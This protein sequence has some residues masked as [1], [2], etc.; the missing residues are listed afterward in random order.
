MESYL[1][2]RI[3][4][5]QHIWLA[6]QS[7]SGIFFHWSQ[8]LSLAWNLSSHFNSVTF[9]S[10]LFHCLIA[11]VAETH[12][13]HIY[14][15]NFPFCSLNQFLCFFPLW[16]MRITGPCSLYH[17]ISCICGQLFCLPLVFVD[18]TFLSQLLLISL[19]FKSF[20]IFVIVLWAFFN[21]LVSFLKKQHPKLNSLCQLRLSPMPSGAE[22]RPCLFYT[23]RSFFIQSRIFHCKA[24]MV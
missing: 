9:H 5:Q 1:L 2:V 6:F 24:S 20:L 12:L 19:I 22:K 23:M 10:S 14:S 18:W 8:Q 11:W 4:H 21:L 3:C 7:Q 15:R 16:L 17:I 13:S